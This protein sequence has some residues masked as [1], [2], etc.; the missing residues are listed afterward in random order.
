MGDDDI[1]HESRKGRAA[2]ATTSKATVASP[3]SKAEKDAT[4][5]TTSEPSRAEQ[6]PLTGSRGDDDDAKAES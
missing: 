2:I 6:A 5:M 3:A 1:N 4:A